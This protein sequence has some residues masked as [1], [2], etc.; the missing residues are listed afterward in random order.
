MPFEL[1]LRSGGLTLRRTTR[2]TWAGPLAPAPIARF[3]TEADAAR[4]KRKL[5]EYTRARS[6]IREV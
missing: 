2:E 6:E 3:E 4:E 1:V 5:P